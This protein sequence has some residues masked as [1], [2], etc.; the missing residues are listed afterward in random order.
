MRKKII[1][2]LL[3]YFCLN[4]ICYAALVSYWKFD[5]GSGTTT[6]DASGNNNTG[7]LVNSPIWVNG[8]VGKG[9]EFDGIDDYVDCGSN[10]ILNITSSITICAWV[11]VKADTAYY[12]IAGKHEGLAPSYGWALRRGDTNDNVEWR[13]STDGSNWIGGETAFGSCQINTWYHLAATSDGHMMRVY[14]N[15]VEHIGGNFPYTFSICASSINVSTNNLMIGNAGGLSMRGIIDEVKIYNHVLS[16]GEILT[17]YYSGQAKTPA[18]VGYWKFDEGNGKTVVD[19]SG[20]NNT[21]ILYNGPEW[22]TGQVGNALQFD[23]LDDNVSIPNSKSLNTPDAVTI[24]AWVYPTRIP[25]YMDDMVSNDDR[26]GIRWWGSELKPIFIFKIND[27]SSNWRWVVSPDAV[28]LNT[29]VHI[30]ATYDKNAGTNNMR[31]YVDGIQKVSDTFT[32]TIECSTAP[33]TIGRYSSRYFQ[34]KID[35]IKIYNTALSASEVLAEYNSGLPDATAP[36]ITITN[37]ADGTTVSE[38]VSFSVNA[39]DNRS[40]KQ[41]DFYVDSILQNTDT[42]SPYAWNWNTSNY[43]NGIHT[44]KAVAIDTSN[45][46]ATAQISVTVSNSAVS[47]KISIE[48]KPTDTVINPM[49]GQSS[50]INFSIP[51]SNTNTSGDT[52]HVV[53]AI[54]NTRDELVKTLID[55]DMP[56]GQYQAIWNGRSFEEDVV[57]SG[58]YLIRLRAGKYTATKKIAVIK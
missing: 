48:I 19:S 47:D 5:E 37:P 50:K 23:G 11:Y 29:W 2:L 12:S 24:S 20:N 16:A 13:I 36:T 42:T 28:S 1:L 17:E 52:V 49:T 39:T 14:I 32:D 9:L 6:T 40:I 31:L 35:E 15:G 58:V 56:E 38:I 26:Y 27:G 43:S 34:G 46:D 30:V 3:S 4:S 8:Q 53:I 22:T 25:I 55:Q 41:V 45:L 44:I 54:Y 21:G 51:K 18:L 7:T 57:A 10:S 33:F